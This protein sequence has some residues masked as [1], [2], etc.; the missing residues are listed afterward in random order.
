[1][2]DDDEESQFERLE[3]EADRAA[4]EVFA[5]GFLTGAI[6]AA[7]LMAMLW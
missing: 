6:F 1:M 3:A 4:F 2:N 5:K 7:V